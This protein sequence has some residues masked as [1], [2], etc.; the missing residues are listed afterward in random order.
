MAI[1]RIF[2]EKD[3]FIF[4]E[5]ITANTGR[6][7]ILE[8]G[9]Y[10]A[11]ISKQGMASRALIK[12]KDAKISEALNLIP[13]SSSYEA[14][15][16][17]YLATASEI[18][19]E[20]TV[21]SYPIYIASGIEWDSGI[22]KFGD[23]PPTTTGVSWQSINAAG[24]VLWDA[25]GYSNYTTGSYKQAYPGGGT[26]YTSSQ[27]TS[28]EFSQTHTMASTHDL[29]IN[30]TPAIQ[31]IYSGELVNKG[32]IIKLQDEYEF[33]ENSSIRLKYFGGNTNTIYPPFLE[34]GWDDSIQTGSLPYLDT[35]VC[36]VV[37]KNNKGKYVDE[38]VQRFRLVSR[39]RYPQRAFLT[40]SIYLENYRLPPE[41]YWGLRDEKT[42]EMVIDFNADHT[43]ISS[44][45]LGSYFDIYMDSLQPERYYRVLIK[46][47]LG[48]STTVID[49]KNIFKVIRNG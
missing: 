21:Y 48:G 28:M 36:Y 17:M 6:D 10:P 49:N 13:E 24:T 34:I 23:I 15:L 19:V 35:D 41:S 8:I 29:C 1:Y 11:N 47:T 2:P 44:D 37:I 45:D 39:P 7:E 20:Y 9:G 16:K 18:P 38:G 25:S 14:N 5:D 31:Q 3:A 27:G 4:T 40:S 43:K 33:Y 26:W 22:G 12:F 42:E 46:T 30:I 32:F